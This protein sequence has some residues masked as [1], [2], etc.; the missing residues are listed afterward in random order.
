MIMCS[1]WVFSFKIL[2]IF[3]E[4][5]REKERERNVNVREKH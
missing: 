3:R 4:G 2:F 5:G 1:S